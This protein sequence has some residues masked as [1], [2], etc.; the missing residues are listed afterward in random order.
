[1]WCCVQIEKPNTQAAD[2]GSSIYVDIGQTVKA[3][4]H[5][6][7]F[8]AAPKLVDETV[9]VLHLHKFIIGAIELPTQS[10]VSNKSA[11]ST[12]DSTV[13][14]V[15]RRKIKE[16]PDQQEQQEQQ[17]ELEQQQEE[18]QEQQEQQQEQQST[19]RT[20]RIGKI[21]GWHPAGDNSDMGS[22]DIEIS[23]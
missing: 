18:N 14:G 3:L 13:D 23:V 16:E 10:N 21:T 4:N 22:V 9:I 19:A 5:L 8:E 7:K 6:V 1:M 20:T 17:E 15:K 2:I 11:M 12:P